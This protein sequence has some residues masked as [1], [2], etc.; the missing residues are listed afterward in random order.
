MLSLAFIVGR[1]FS[2]DHLA[3]RF[4]LDPDPITLVPSLCQNAVFVPGFG[5]KTYCQNG[6]LCKY[7]PELATQVHWGIPS[8]TN[9]RRVLAWTKMVRVHPFALMPVDF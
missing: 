8:V 4:V 2:G 7:T 9:L 6:F 3:G 1:L 5:G